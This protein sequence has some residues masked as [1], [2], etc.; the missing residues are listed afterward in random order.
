MDNHECLSYSRK[1][2][3]RRRGTHEEIYSGYM[4][5]LACTRTKDINRGGNAIS[6]CKVRH[7]STPLRFVGWLVGEAAEYIYHLLQRTRCRRNYTTM[8]RVFT[9]EGNGEEASEGSVFTFD[10]LH[11]VF[12]LT[13]VQQFSSSS[14]ARKNR[15]L[16]GVARWC[17]R[18][19]A[20]DPLHH[21]IVV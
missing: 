10:R 4:K 18:V 5:P 17:A 8:A 14:S 15:S 19:S 12:R 7:S 11:T 9:A 13:Q 6:S 16:K 3:T 21:S 20:I 2:Q 1:G